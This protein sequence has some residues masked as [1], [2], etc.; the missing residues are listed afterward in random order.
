MHELSLSSAIVDTALRHC[1]GRRV[2]RVDVRVGRLRQV[3]PDSLAF[4]FE[5]VAR[6]TLCDG[7]ELE[8]EQIAARLR[9]DECGIDWDPAPPPLATHEPFAG[10]GLPP[11]PSFRCPGCGGASSEVLAGDELEVESIEVAD[12]GGRATA[13]THNR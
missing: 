6:D 5:I 8:L 13:S 7:A 9:C 1:D 12:A 3:V 11:V 2:T 4:Y 10:A